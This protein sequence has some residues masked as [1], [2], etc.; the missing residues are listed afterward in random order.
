MRVYIVDSGVQ[1]SHVDFKEGRVV[2]GHTVR[3]ALVDACLQ[4]LIARA[5]QHQHPRHTPPDYRPPAP[6]P[7]PFRLL[8]GIYPPL[9]AP[10]IPLPLSSLPRTQSK[11]RDECASCQA[12]NGILPPNGINCNDHGTHVASI[13]GGLDHGVAK[14]VTLVPAFSCFSILCPDGNRTCVHRNDV[15]ASLE[16]VPRPPAPPQPE[17]LPPL[18]L[19]AL[20]PPVVAHS[21]PTAAPRPLCC[22][23]VLTDCAAHPEA[24][25]VATQATHSV[26]TPVGTPVAPLGSL[27][28]GLYGSP[29]RAPREAASAQPYSCPLAWRCPPPCF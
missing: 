19:A 8:L 27:H 14:E 15:R 18:P 22:R 2:K 4:R 23:W 9:T 5:P 29:R 7:T 17:A 11:V 20:Q 24:R 28:L 10:C 21:T 12:V 13:V 3:A 16:Y 25:C 1:G 26:G 6:T